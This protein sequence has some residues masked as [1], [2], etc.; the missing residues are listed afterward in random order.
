M[1]VDRILIGKPNGKRYLF[2]DLCVVVTSKLIIWKECVKTWTVFSRPVPPD[3]DL[4]VRKPQFFRKTKKLRLSFPTYPYVCVIAQLN[5]NGKLLYLMKFASGHCDL[6]LTWSPTQLPANEQGSYSDRASNLRSGSA[7][8]ESRLRHRL[9]WLKIF[10]GFS[11]DL[12]KCLD[13]IIICVYSFH[14]F[15]ISLS[16]V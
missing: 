9:S 6:S 12:G 1:L 16:T 14:V 2:L 7:R 11:L 8:F 4:L 15:S 10:R 3:V 13:I 5:L